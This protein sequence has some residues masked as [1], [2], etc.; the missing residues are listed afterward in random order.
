MWPERFLLRTATTG[1]PSFHPELNPFH[2][3]KTPQNVTFPFD[4]HLAGQRGNH[5]RSW[6]ART[7]S[8]F[9]VYSQMV[10]RGVRMAGARDQGRAVSQ[11]QECKGMPVGIPRMQGSR[12]TGAGEALSALHG[13]GRH[14]L[15]QVVPAGWWLL[16]RPAATTATT[17]HCPP[18]PP[19]VV[20]AWSWVKSAQK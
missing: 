8:R 2:Q 20:V 1:P 3:K 10:T 11:G 12:L 6:V 5:G 13:L 9:S 7:Y 14:C 15:P 18:P 19:P 17:R 16:L 4:H